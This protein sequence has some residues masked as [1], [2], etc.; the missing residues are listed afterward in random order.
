[1]VK[2]AECGI[3]ITTC[4]GCQV[5]LCRSHLYNSVLSRRLM[6][7]ECIAEEKDNQGPHE[8]YQIETLDELEDEKNVHVALSDAMDKV[9]DQLGL[10]GDRE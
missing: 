1:M 6:C 3:E 5:T 10:K 8:P 2:C 4:Q 7:L 9:I